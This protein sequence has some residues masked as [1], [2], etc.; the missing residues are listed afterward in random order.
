L[1]WEQLKPSSRAVMAELL[2]HGPLSRA[3]LARRLA[4]SGASLTK[5][6][7][8]LLE[9]GLI[10]DGRG[11]GPTVARNAPVRRGR[12]SHPLDVA[13][14]SY[15][16]I[17]IKLTSS[18]LFAVRTDLRATIGEEL[19]SALPSRDPVDVVDAIDRA[20][21]SLD[22]R[23]E[24]RR[25]GIS[26]AGNICVGDTVVYDSMF[27]GWREVP[28]VKLVAER[29]GREIVLS[30]DVRALAAAQHWFGAA[31]GSSCFA[32]L[33][34]GAG[35]GCALVANNGVLAGNGGHAGLV[36]HLPIRE[37]GPL[38]DRGHRG[39]ANSYLSLDGILR[40]I[41]V[42]GGDRVN[43]ID[44]CLELAADG[45]PPALAV[46]S[47][48]CYA[49]GVLVAYVANLIGPDRVILSGDGIVICDI[50]PDA[51]QEG[52]KAALDDDA[53]DFELIVRPFNF[54]EWSRGAAAVAIQSLIRPPGFIIN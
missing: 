24:V 5:L 28:L 47:D 11:P 49:L 23:G 20:V 8:P 40:T 13:V 35:V 42:V 1:D 3:E 33:T 45:Y 39:C 54:M 41:Q 22:P 36:A 4:Y 37:G 15:P 14:A 12:R 43:D 53:A 46:F 16:I 18:E 19:H 48:A 34:V 25:I 21:G 2:L 51:L 38:C 31:R 9:A 50:S 7:S 6:S 17:G 29:T 27:L 10:V 52:M 32:V 26:L 44:D 30:N